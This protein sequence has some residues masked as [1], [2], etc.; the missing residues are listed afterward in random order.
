MSTILIKVK[1]KKPA[2]ASK[3]AKTGMVDTCQVIYHIFDQSPEEES[4]PYCLK[5]NIGVIARAPFDEGDSQ[6]VL[7]RTLFFLRAIGAMGISA[8]RENSKSRTV[9]KN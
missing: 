1:G 7:G 3:A 6:G 2:S 8:A 5:N 9:L 4:F